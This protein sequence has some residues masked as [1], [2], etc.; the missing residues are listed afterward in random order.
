MLSLENL[1]QEKF[2][3]LL[4]KMPEERRQRIE[5][6]TSE[7]LAEMP[8]QELR[9]ALQLTQQQVAAMLNMNQAAVSKMEGQT[10]MYVST[11]RRFIEAMGGEL[12][13]VAHFPQGDVEIGQFK[14][15]EGDSE[16]VSAA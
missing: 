7:L 12:R 3:S 14:E 15:A 5:K 2:C 6:H 9:K 10:D 16:R 11:L 1:Q 13:I 8:L 4:E